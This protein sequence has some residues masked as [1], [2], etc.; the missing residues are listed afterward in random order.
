[1]RVGSVAGAALACACV[2]V[3][4]EPEPTSA[5]SPASV[6][7]VERVGCLG[8]QRHLLG[9]SGRRLSVRYVL[10]QLPRGRYVFEDVRVELGDPFGLERAVVSLT[11]P[12]AL[13]VY[14]RLVRLG[15]LFS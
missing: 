10:E 2:P 15:R 14:P 12:G 3:V 7:L 9:R 4:V 5:V 13:L 11:A 6:T 8:E 1:R